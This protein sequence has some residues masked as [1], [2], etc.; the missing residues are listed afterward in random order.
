MKHLNNTYLLCRNIETQYKISISDPR[1]S[2]ILALN[3]VLNISHWFIVALGH[4][5]RGKYIKIY[6]CIYCKSI[7]TDTIQ[8]ELIV[9]QIG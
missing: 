4:Q 7:L 2:T 6:Q 8:I 1:T 3:A 9:P 5:H